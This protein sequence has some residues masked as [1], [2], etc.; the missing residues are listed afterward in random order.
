MCAELGALEADVSKERHATFLNDAS[1]RE[2]QIIIILASFERAP[3]PTSSDSAR[4]SKVRECKMRSY[5]KA[6]PQEAAELTSKYTEDVK[7]P[8][9]FS[10]YTF[11][12]FTTTRAI[13][14]TA[15]C[16]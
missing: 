12:R 10:P 4:M 1:A 8:R 5:A 15:T 11:I 16:T 6:H 2:T 3:S 9:K 7:L 14:T 13:H